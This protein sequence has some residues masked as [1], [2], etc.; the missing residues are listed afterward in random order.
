MALSMNARVTVASA[1]LQRCAQRLRIYCALSAVLTRAAPRRAAPSRSR[2][3]RSSAVSR[4][5]MG[6]TRKARAPPSLSQRARLARGC[7]LTA[8]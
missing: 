3:Q 8:A 6:A 1:P 4:P 7:C 5:A 2:V